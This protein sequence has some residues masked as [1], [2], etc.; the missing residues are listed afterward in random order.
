M[1]ST[2][3]P[4][5]IGID[6][7]GS[8][9]AVVPLKAGTESISN[10]PPVTLILWTVLKSGKSLVSLARARGRSFQNSAMKYPNGPE[11]ESESRTT[12][13]KLRLSVAETLQQAAPQI[14]CAGILLRQRQERRRGQTSDS[15]CVCTTHFPT[16][17]R[18]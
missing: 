13:Q 18:R 16:G 8:L 5:V 7:L 17:V 3:R 6:I 9:Y 14:R 1:K 10:A 12:V 15:E 11:N 4:A 2:E